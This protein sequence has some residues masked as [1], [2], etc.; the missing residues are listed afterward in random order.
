MAHAFLTP[1]PSVDLRIFVL[2]TFGTSAHFTD[3][4]MVDFVP[5]VLPLTTV[6]EVQ[7][8]K[9]RFCCLITVH[10]HKCNEH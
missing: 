9:G 6:S 5:F 3:M 4:L 10:K 8:Q 1:T 7:L 2:F